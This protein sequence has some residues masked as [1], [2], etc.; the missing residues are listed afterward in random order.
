MFSHRCHVTA[1]PCPA[2]FNWFFF[3]LSVLV[4]IWH[5]EL[6]MK[7]RDK[8]EIASCSCNGGIEGWVASYFM[9]EV[10][11]NAWW[12]GKMKQQSLPKWGREKWDWICKGGGPDDY[13]CGL[14]WIVLF[15]HFCVHLWSAPLTQNF[16]WKWMAKM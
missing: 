9:N 8:R 12:R 3:L 4:L 15:I 1:I 2:I 6:S 5:L 7:E 11:S 10:F 16:N 14:L 13:E